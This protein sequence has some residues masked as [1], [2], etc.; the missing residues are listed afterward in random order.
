MMFSRKSLLSILVAVFVTAGALAVAP[1]AFAQVV[2]PTS[3][4]STFAEQAGFSTGDGLTIT[5]ARL[6]RTVMSILGILAVILILIGGFKYMTSGGNDEK[7]KSAKK[8]FSSAIVGLVIIL[9]AFAIVQFILGQL[10]GALGGT[11][12]SSGSG[13]TGGG[14]GDGGGTS[15]QFV[16]TS[17]NTECAYA[18]K[19]LQLQFLFSQRATLES[20]NNGGI[21]V[22][23]SGTDV[24]GT[25]QATD[26]SAATSSK[27]ISFVPTQDCGA[28]YKVS[29][30]CFDANTDYD[31]E[32]SET[33]LKSSNDLSYK[34]DATYPCTFSFTTGSD[35][36][37]EGPTTIDL[38]APEEGAAVFTNEIRP[39]QAYTLDDT[40]VSSLYF[41]IDNGD[42]IYDASLATDS[43]VGALSSENYFSTADGTE[44]YVSSDYATGTHAVRATGVDCAG[45]SKTSS[46]V[47]VEIYPA[48]CNNGVQD[49]VPDVSE[50][51]A[52][53]EVDCGGN[54]CG[55]CDGSPCTSNAQCASGYCSGE[56]DS[57]TGL[58]ID[59]VCASIPQI[60]SVSPGDGAEGNIVS[61]IG[62]GFGTTPGS[63]QFLGAVDTNGTYSNPVTASEYQCETGSTW[64]DEQIIVQVSGS[65]KDGPIRVT[66]GIDATHTE[67]YVDD[68]NDDYGATIND[69]DVNSVV[70]PGLC[71]PSPTFG[72]GRSVVGLSGN[73]FFSAG[74]TDQGTS[75]VY[76]EN[77]EASEYFSWK[78]TE[79]SAQVPLLNAR[80][81]STQVW[82]G[83]YVCATSQGV[84]GEIC[85]TDLDC[86]EASGETCETMRCSGSDAF[87]DTDEDCGS[88]GDCVSLRQG[89][90]KVSFTV[91]DSETSSDPII[92][93]VVSGW[94][95]CS[96]S[97]GG[98][99]CAAVDGFSEE[100][101]G[102]GDGDS[103]DSH[104]DWGPPGQYVTITGTGFG[105]GKGNVIF[106]DST[107]IA[108]GD[109]DFPEACGDDTWEDTEITFKVPAEYYATEGSGDPVATGSSYAVTVRTV[110]GAESE[111]VEFTILGGT[112]GPGIC[113]IDPSSGPA[114]TATVTADGVVISGDNLGSKYDM[115]DVLFSSE[116]SAQTLSWYD[117]SVT[118]D[119]VPVG[120]ATGPVYV[121]DS[122]GYRSNGL[123]FQVGSCTE[124]TITC[125]TGEECCGNG[126]CSVSCP[127]EPEESHYSWMF[128][129]GNIP[130]TPKVS[131]FCESGRGTSPAPWNFRSASEDIC[132]NSAV[133]ATFDQAIDWTDPAPKVVV[134]KEDETVV[135]GEIRTTSA[136]LFEWNPAD[137]E[138]L[139][140][141]TY[142]VTLLS[143]GI[144]TIETEDTPAAYMANDYSWTFTTSTSTE[145]CKIGSVSAMPSE[146]TAV[147]E[148]E[149]VNYS[150]QALSENDYCV[151]LNCT[152]YGWTWT[153]SESDL[154]SIPASV[155]STTSEGGLTVYSCANVATA[156]AETLSGSPVNIKATAANPDGDVDPEDNGEL[157]I[158]FTDPEVVSWT[159]SCDT[160]CLNAAISATFNTAMASDLSVDTVEI[161]TCHDDLCAYEEIVAGDLWTASDY[162]VSHVYGTT[163]LDLVHSGEGQKQFEANTWYRIVID[164]SV[165]SVSGVALSE[166]GSN[167]PSDDN[168][169]FEDAFSWKFKTKDTTEVCAVDRVVTDPVAASATIIGEQTL[170]Q[171]VPF[172]SPDDCEVD[173]QQLDASGYDWDAWESVDSTS[174]AKPETTDDVATMLRSAVDP[175]LLTTRLE[176]GCSTSCLH[177]GVTLSKYDPVCG[178][179]D[180]THTSNE[181]SF[182][183]LTAGGEEC[184]GGSG[185]SSSCLFVGN[186]DP[187]TCGDGSFESSLGEECDDGNAI[188][189]DGC[190]SVCLNAGSSKAG[191]RCGDGTID[192]AKYTGGE[193]CDDDNSFSGDG[194]SSVCLNEGGEVVDEGSYSTCGN[195]GVPEE[196]EDCDDGDTV[197]DDGCSAECLYEGADVCAFECS[198]SGVNC[199]GIGSLCDD[200]DDGSSGGSC[201]PVVAPCSGDGRVDY[202]G[203]DG[204]WS[205]QSE[206][207]D[208][209]GTDDGDGCSSEGLSEGSSLD[210][211][212]YCGDGVITGD[213]DTGGEECDAAAASTDAHYGY[214]GVSRISASAASDVVDGTA[215][216]TI[217]ATESD[218]G[219]T[220]DGALTLICSS[221]TDED[222]GNTELYGSGTSGCCFERPEVDGQY[223]MDGDGDVCRNT[224]I[225]V[226]FT[227]VMDSTSLSSWTDSNED[228]I[229]NYG[230]GHQN[231][232]LELTLLDGE[233][234]T[235]LNCPSTYTQ[236][237]LAF[238]ESTSRSWIARAWN[239]VVRSVSQIFASVAHAE[240][241][242]A[243]QDKTFACIIPV[244]YDLTTESM[245]DSV[246]SHVALNIA[247]ALEADSEYQLVVVEDADPT[248]AADTIS[249]VLSEN[250][251]SID[252]SGTGAVRLE[253]LEGDANIVVST[254]TTGPE[255]C[256]LDSVTVE[257]L[258][259]VDSL[260]VPYIAD[261]SIGYFTAAD[262]THSVLASAYSIRG[263]QEVAI[264]ETTAYGWSWTWGTSVA[265]DSTTNTNVIDTP[266]ASESTD[267]ETST[268]TA[269]GL[270]GTEYV[271]ST[272]TFDE[273]NTF[274]DANDAV[275]G[276]LLLT[277]NVCD[278]LPTIGFPYVDSLSK[279]SFFYCRDYGVAGDE[280][281][282]LP[283]IGT[284][285][286]GTYVPIDVTSYTTDII[287]ELIFKVEGTSD[288]IGVRVLPNGTYLSPYAWYDEMGFTGSPSGTTVDG[289]N[290]VTDGNTTYVAATNVKFGTIYSNVVAVSYTED[291]EATSQ[292]IFSQILEN[293]SFNANDSIVTDVN[294][295]QSAADE[296]YQTDADTGEFIACEWDGDCESGQTCDAE[297]AKLTRDLQRLQDVTVI[298][299][300]LDDYGEANGLCSVT[301][302]QACTSDDSCPGDETCEASVPK[303]A[304]GT[305]ISSFSFSAWP[306]WASGLGNALGSSVPSD[307]LNEFFAC[308]GENYESATCWN[309]IA[310]TFM[311][312]DESHVYGYRSVGGLSFELKAALEYEDDVWYGEI[313]PTDLGTVTLEYDY[314][315]DSA[316]L[317]RGFI[318]GSSAEAFC[319]GDEIGVSAIC[320]DGIRNTDETSDNYEACE[321]GDVV[322]GDTACDT[323][324]DGIGEGVLCSSD[325]DCS[326]GTCEAIDCGTDGGTISTTCESDCSSYRTV[327]ESEDEDGAACVDYSCG[328]GV[329][330]T[331]ETCD[332][333]DANGTYGHCGDDC[334]TD[335]AFFCGDG[336]LAGGEECDCG[337]STNFSDLMS[338][339]DATYGTS[340][341]AYLNSC[342]NSNG[343]WER[344]PTGTCSYDCKSPGPSCGDGEINGSEECD[345]DYAAWA[346]ALCDDGTECTT[347][348]D[349]SSGTC[350]TGTT[351]PD[352]SAACGTSIVC[353][354]ASD[355]GT[356]CYG[357]PANCDSGS[358]T[359]GF[360]DDVSDQGIPCEDDQPDGATD[361]DSY[362][363]DAVDGRTTCQFEC[364]TVTYN[365]TRTRTCKTAERLMCTWDDWTS[366]VSEEYCG[367]GSV[368]GTEECDDGNDDD[369]DACTTSCEENVCG[370]GEV[371]SGVESCDDGSDNGTACDASYDS[372][373]HYCTANCQYKTTSGEYCGDGEVNGSEYCD[374]SDL[375]YYCFDNAYID[376][377]SDGAV[378]DHAMDQAGTCDATDE[379]TATG[380][381]SGFTCRKMGICNGGT[382]NGEYCTMNPD[383]TGTAHTTRIN[384]KSACDG[385]TCVAPTCSLTCEASCPFTYETTAVLAT[386]EEV[387]AAASDSIDL[388]SYDPLSEEIDQASLSLPACT[389]GT[390]ITADVNT[391]N[392]ETPSVA[393]YFITDYT[394]T[395][396]RDIN[397]ATIASDDTSTQ[398]RI[399]LVS[400]AEAS[401]ISTLYDSLS[402]G[403]LQIGLLRLGALY[404][405]GTAN[406]GYLI[407]MELGSNDEN[408]LIT[409]VEGY[410]AGTDIDS[411]PPFYAG[412]KYAI[413]QLDQTTADAK[414]IVLLSDGEVFEDRS[415]DYCTTSTNAG[416]CYGSYL[417]LACG[418]ESDNETDYYNYYCCT[419]EVADGLL[420]SC[421]ADNDVGADAA[422]RGSGDVLIYT[423][424][425]TATSTNAYAS[426]MAHLSSDDCGEDYDD[427]SDCLTRTYSYSAQDEA[428]VATMYD[429]IIDSVLGVTVGLTV[430]ET[431]TPGTV[432]SGHNRELPFPTNFEC[433]GEEMNIP[434]TVDFNGGGYISLDDIAFTYCPVP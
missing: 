91:I 383:S 368:D 389:V 174:N 74:E 398:S 191:T 155:A 382:Q 29:D 185:C 347:D 210:Y 245:T 340:S 264:Q 65:M 420:N 314:D 141:T 198:L 192:Y 402:S 103:C 179:G 49:V 90:N 377:D 78:D 242:A 31:I 430:D 261:P 189:T 374:G 259:T 345:G 217:T 335:S 142:T 61:I 222:C 183:D 9:S 391:S 434:M 375:P 352:G 88:D 135:E 188:D 249:G 216:A 16:L 62:S 205:D 295:C 412:L 418:K 427:I 388:Y 133:T 298:A 354:G 110:P 53:E 69:F 403:D 28:E 14:Y 362:I 212:S 199:T 267:V 234:V 24:L 254:F 15:S 129:T 330:E 395:M 56:I 357:T 159:P 125:G 228:G 38:K 366:C 379:G 312:P 93:A 27:S 178:D 301:T 371:Y 406:E 86:A 404:N 47:T 134:T 241:S 54:T 296:S 184:D 274:E 55:A 421:S 408:D 196:G 122:S 81:Y 22:Q 372:T 145:P 123:N 429:A 220:G 367:N 265:A 144:H 310:A 206:D 165:T 108:Y 66:T 32:L 328:N 41:T 120:S 221:V 397:G 248:N 244:T 175:L 349:C 424:G 251:V 401:A 164:G 126:S 130:A 7:I 311:C 19:N 243:D 428:G 276:T 350:G 207:C 98:S 316:D 181:D 97:E 35:V 50:D 219:E 343:Q 399:A 239:W 23:K 75:T 288:A 272:A 275:S 332:D 67:A 380:C 232:Y 139:P 115:A 71:P 200:M 70:R 280:S 317:E 319:T 327:T 63:V 250:A 414:I 284:L 107:G 44:W 271:V 85:S 80:A 195:G 148:N 341:W 365:L 208:D 177:S 149:R 152:A 359:D 246:G 169:Y 387:G 202:T 150:G 64:T 255:I 132:V 413:Q 405:P 229:F 370:D 20:I 410:A 209:G 87:C 348:D 106:T 315:G 40:G 140:S 334:S 431:L 168:G 253:G 415:N 214:W 113:N 384:D 13:G 10:V 172:G 143:S 331:G 270:T 204:A 426:Y 77:Y 355:V 51:L 147:A 170:W 99:L 218:S 166:S 57:T 46:D 157:T 156:L 329:V 396:T 82:V 197:D 3:G 45:H 124:G 342:A 302:N 287:Q 333:G 422:I 346:G 326:T 263:G 36:D 278:N 76:F 409:T 161:Y 364:G 5:I 240:L 116:V 203:V 294:L 21:R 211:S 344:R 299:G 158:N 257:D 258:G 171:A 160:V 8:L 373:C 59:G 118:T 358:C 394:V 411:G 153:S 293:W 224:A 119:T 187:A 325:D 127:K 283:E 225:Y 102:R 121:L 300:L 11:S 281:D 336:Y 109:F 112:P 194:C 291:A 25:F 417:P 154:A 111:G 292:E 369:T 273:S 215:S 52:E 173:G 305:F 176:A 309:S 2:D 337:E 338:G 104:D 162:S 226:N 318:K 201:L 37:T 433:T 79:I 407:D 423:A 376:A 96:G 6:I 324:G 235:A 58:V 304:D 252:A 269:S 186:S 381:E 167:Y 306:S 233:E 26:G 231:L 237:Y 260:T 42:S 289:Y 262:E 4:L 193:D 92:A 100:C 180:V 308:D 227:D 131:I 378:D 247:D 321:I 236:S 339:T 84:R 238:S 89:S 95:G 323:D 386:T 17:V 303:L 101:D 351:A 43:T 416:S 425:I 393:V 282:D 105:T 361:H 390:K 182:G 72:V 138:F 136:Y 285:V 117:A 137:G 128:S 363:G 83:D 286:D 213:E 360:C 151:A 256:T 163:L 290:A 385:G 30:R 94:M 68:T 266:E 33:F 297:K 48:S 307:P 34:C 73:N 400:A 230:E 432:T 392:V 313:D 353:S 190:S 18:L 320:G 419:K 1:H 356:P 39:L 146:F 277:A 12:T 60:T 268:A 114:S 279:F 223:P 322:S